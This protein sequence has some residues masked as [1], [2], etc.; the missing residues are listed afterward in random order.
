MALAHH[1]AAGGDQ[2]RRGEAKF[3][4]ASNAPITTS[5]PVRR[6]PSICTAIRERS[7]FRTKV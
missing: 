1:D 4:G 6:P 7:R 3:L 2:G 5:R